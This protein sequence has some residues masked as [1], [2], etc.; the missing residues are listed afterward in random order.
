[1]SVR[2]GFIFSEDISDGAPPADGL[3]VNTFSRQLLADRCSEATAAETRDRAVGVDGHDRVR[4]GVGAFG[5]HGKGNITIDS[6]AVMPSRCAVVARCERDIGDV[7]RGGMMNP[8]RRGALAIMSISE[9]DHDGDQRAVDAIGSELSLLVTRAHDRPAPAEGFVWTRP[10]R[11]AMR[12]DGS[13][14]ISRGSARNPVHH[15]K[16]GPPKRY[17]DGQGRHLCSIQSRAG[18]QFT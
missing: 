5:A 13:D 16:Q 7:G 4:P 8:S 11:R 17:S 10:T 6:I 12:T 3:G 2:N 1:M 9:T 18:G 15:P 14:E